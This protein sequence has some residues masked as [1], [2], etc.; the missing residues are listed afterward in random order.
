MA[1]RGG[2]PRAA[3]ALGSNLG[4]R[5]EN[6]RFGVRELERR[7]DRV[8]A[9]RVYRSP[10]REGAEGGDFLN[11]CVEGRPFSPVGGDPRGLMEELQYIEMA[12]GRSLRRGSGE[13][14]TLDLD[15]LLVGRRVVRRPGLRLPHSRMAER[16][17]VLRPLAELLPD[18]RHPETGRTVRELADRVDADDLRPLEWER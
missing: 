13:A 2:A 7:L 18:W 4:D 11:M 12:A 15:L 3:V 14:R 1:D 16:G 8:R 17:F 9:S 5:E 6:L 10:P